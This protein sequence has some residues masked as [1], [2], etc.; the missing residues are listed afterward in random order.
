MKTF[1]ILMLLSTQTWGRS[2]VPDRVVTPSLDLF[3]GGNKTLPNGDI[4]V[5]V[6]TYSKKGTF[7]HRG[8]STILSK[9]DYDAFVKLASPVFEMIPDESYSGDET[10]SRRGT[11]FSIGEN[12][13]LTNHHVLDPNFQ[14][15]NSCADF[16]VKNKEGDT[17]DCKAVH[18]CSKAQDICLIEMSPKVKTKRDC[19][20]CSG[21]KYEV[22]LKDGPKLKLRPNYSPA[23]R[24]EV[25]TTAIGNSSGFGIHLSQGRGI[26]IS[27]DRLYFYA[28]IT[29]GNSGGP[30]LNSDGEVIGVVKL[31]SKKT[32]G[33]DP[34]QV[35]NIAASSDVV[36]KLIRNAL[37]DN[38]GTLA[39]FN[40]AV[41]E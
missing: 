29:Q 34:N 26:T 3:D 7:I 9:N 31:Q 33:T 19:T 14:N 15:T 37:R 12:L 25:I 41:I 21:T 16:Q 13:V 17:F 36:I 20:F 35:Y 30:L 8:S 23:S 40:S 27:N 28:P 4:E 5:K 11:A 32:I 18:F 39:K 10:Y 38:P 22:S 2:V 1:I 6:T 24:A